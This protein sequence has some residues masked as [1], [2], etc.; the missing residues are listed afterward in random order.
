MTQGWV[1]KVV[2][3][4]PSSDTTVVSRVIDLNTNEIL[5][6][7]RP[8]SPE[9]SQTVVEATILKGI[10]HQSIIELKSTME[11]PHGPALLFPYYPYG[12]FFEIIVRC[13]SLAESYVKVIMFHLLDGVD[14][15]HERGIV[16]RDI[17][18]D[19]IFLASCDVNDV[20]LA[21]FGLA[22]VLPESGFTECSVGSARYAAPEIW[23]HHI[24]T[25]KVDIWSLGVT[26]FVLLFGRPLYVIN[27]AIEP[28]INSI[29]EAIWELQCS[30]P[31][32]EVSV[33]CWDLLL[34]MLELDPA[35]RISAAAALK[36][37]W[38]TPSE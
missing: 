2:D 31:P 36:H 10:R 4:F 23:E 25:E 19:N 37:D 24:S 17:K 12:D 32:S 15:L 21:D 18:P 29:S 6:V 11:T 3:D 30:S 7:K 1:C 26:M 38:F 16:H 22:C 34:Q 33:V 28:P 13:G 9:C 5:V 35:K 8:R 27:P 14:Y 20:V